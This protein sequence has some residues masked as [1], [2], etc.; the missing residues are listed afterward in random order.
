MRSLFL[1]WY[2]AT[3]KHLLCDEK[4]VP[5]EHLKVVESHVTS[6]ILWLKFE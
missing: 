1:P 3:E 5:E 2:R 6:W 4:K